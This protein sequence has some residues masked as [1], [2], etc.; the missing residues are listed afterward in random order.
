MAM[1]NGSLHPLNYSTATAGGLLTDN[2]SILTLA[3]SSKRRRR[4]SLDTDASVRAL[5]PSSLWGGSRESLPLS[6]L[7]GNFD[8]GRSIAGDRGS[9]YGS[10]SFTTAR[11]GDAAS[12]SYAGSMRDYAGGSGSIMGEISGVSPLCSSPYAGMTIIGNRESVNLGRSSRRNSAWVRGEEEEEDDD[13]D[14]DATNRRRSMSVNGDGDDGEGRGGDGASMRDGSSSVGIWNGVYG[15]R[16][17]TREKG[18][19]D[20]DGK[21]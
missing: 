11:G 6:V 19:K 20:M 3:S 16:E 9:I 5:A 13:E 12:M 15:K 18:R 4:H 8:T 17:D 2:A 1:N 21:N 7:S 10:T 14:D